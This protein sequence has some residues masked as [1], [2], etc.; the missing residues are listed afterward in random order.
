M[1][2]TF[3]AEVILTPPVPFTSPEHY[4]HRAAQVS[5]SPA[6]APRPSRT[7]LRPEGRVRRAGAGG[8]VA[9]RAGA[10]KVAYEGNLKEPGSHF[11]TNQVPARSALSTLRSALSTLPTA[12]VCLPDPSMHAR[13]HLPPSESPLTVVLSRNTCPRTRVSSKTP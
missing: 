13:R 9:D 3:G 6:V 7:G 10:M 11:F 4:F 12:D 1:M 8:W 5:G 2:R